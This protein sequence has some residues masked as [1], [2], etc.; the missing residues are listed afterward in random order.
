M[1]K[2]QT[3]KHSIIVENKHFMYTCQTTWAHSHP[4]RQQQINGFTITGNDWSQQHLEWSLMK[5]KRFDSPDWAIR[6]GLTYCT[7]YTDCSLHHDDGVVDFTEYC[8]SPLG[9]PYVFVCFSF[10]T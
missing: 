2:P 5:H 7:V 3:Y 4:S 10:A 9:N 1:L 8:A 6:W